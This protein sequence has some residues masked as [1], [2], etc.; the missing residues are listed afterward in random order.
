MDNLPTHKAKGIIEAI[1]SVG[2]KVVF[3]SPDSPDFNQARKLLVKIET[4]FENCGISHLRR[5]RS[6]YL[7]MIY[8]V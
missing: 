3:L 4:I 1:E 5:T 2:A 8:V 7:C 6:S